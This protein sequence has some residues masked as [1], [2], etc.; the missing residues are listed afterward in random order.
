D[1]PRSLAVQPF[2]ETSV[3]VG[4]AS[5]LGVAAFSP[6]LA[7]IPN[8]TPWGTLALPLLLWTALRSG[9]RDTATLVLILSGLLL[10]G[11]IVESPPLASGA[12]ESSTL[13][14][15]MV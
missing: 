10:W 7:D 8:R 11:T 6:L 13:F 4:L 1:H 12:G 3:L 2:L 15:A 14:A 5:V 9:P